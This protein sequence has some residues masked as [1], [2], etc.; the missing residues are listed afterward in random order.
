M[1]ARINFLNY[2]GRLMMY[3]AV[4][5]RVNYTGRLMMYSAV[6]TRVNVA[7]FRMLF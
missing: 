2:T 3:S 7:A 1:R 5:T 4:S 6:S